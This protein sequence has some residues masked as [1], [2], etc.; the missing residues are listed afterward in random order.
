MIYNAA[1]NT[2]TEFSSLKLTEI[3]EQN[4]FIQKIERCD[5]D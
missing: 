3:M 1:M 4:P 5:E 2:T